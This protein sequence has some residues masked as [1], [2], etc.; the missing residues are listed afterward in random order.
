ML[1]VPSIKIFYID[2]YLNVITDNDLRK[3]HLAMGS[4]AEYIN[5]HCQLADTSHNTISVWQKQDGT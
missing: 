5:I 3:P 1:H 2:M 4:V